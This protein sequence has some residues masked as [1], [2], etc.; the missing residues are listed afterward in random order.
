MATAA[1]NRH[2]SLQWIFR[3]NLVVPTRNPFDD[4]T[5]A[6]TTAAEE[7]NSDDCHWLGP[8]LQLLLDWVLTVDTNGI[9]QH[10]QAASTCAWLEKLLL[11]D[12][13]NDCHYIAL[14]P[15]DFLCPGFIDLHIHAPQYA[16][17]GTGTDRSLFK[18]LD[19]YSYPA[20]TRLQDLELAEQV[21]RK[22]VQRT[23]KT[24]TTTAVYFATLH[25]EPCKVLVD[26]ALEYGQ[27][28]LVGKVSMDRHSPANYCQSV[29]TN[30]H[31]TEALI[32]YVH[33]RVG[34]ADLSVTRTLGRPLPLVLPLVTPRFLPTCS[35]A[36]L[37]GLGALVQKH[38]CHVTTHISQSVGQVAWS[39]RLDAAGRTDAAVLAAHQLLTDK[40]ILAH[41]LCL[42]TKDWDL[43]KDQGATLAHCPMSNFFFGG[44]ALR[45]RRLL[46]RGNRV[47]LATDV[48]GGYYPSM[49]Q[50]C[51][52]A[53]LASLSRSH[54]DCPVNDGGDA[55]LTTDGQPETEVA[56]A[57][58][59]YRHA[60]YL[61]TLG[62]AQALQL[63]H[64]IGSL[65]VGMEFDAMIWSATVPDSPLDVF[66]TDNTEDV[67]Q[68]ICLLGD[69]RNVTR[70][71]VQGR[72]VTVG[73]KKDGGN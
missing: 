21:Y 73:A 25:L 57:A 30:L 5:A 17:A 18:W 24:G 43:L 16:F 19:T 63:A 65:A 31:E 37:Q 34:R 23:L 61:A 8:G 71:F 62:G 56:S 3:G 55:S 58:L 40:C 15:H 27:R 26:V 28:A 9:I 1:S 72:D 6:T 10:L 68:K 60:F 67:F 12:N 41:G 44:T 70:V 51:R 36:L 48:A 35:H 2:N 20:E 39:R 4:S 50:A 22:V 54:Q 14:G 11:Q 7:V 69:D 59:D 66:A 46:E 38:N 52:T 32:D 13:P 33:E 53:V 29:E 47:G 45:T 49:L 42:T 64:K